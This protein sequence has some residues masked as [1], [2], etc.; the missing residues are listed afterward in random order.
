MG[1]FRYR[2]F[3]RLVETAGLFGFAVFWCL[4]A[5]RVARGT[6]SGNVWVVFPAVALGYLFADFIG[7]LVHFLADNFGDETL[8][9]FGPAFIRPFREHH[10]SPE[11]M[12]EHDY[13]E[14][15]GANALVA[16]FVLVP[17]ALFVDLLERNAGVAVGSFV[18]AWMLATL[19]T[20]SIHAWAHMEHPPVYARLMQRIGLA[21]SKAEHA[22]H[23]RPPHASHYCITTGWLNPVLERIAFFEH[24]RRVLRRNGSSVGTSDVAST[25]VESPES[26]ANELSSCRES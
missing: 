19:L 4:L 8:A 13:I 10:A 3:H 15:N 24:L 16:L 14:R 22:M 17:S 21:V 25:V 5:L 20:N 2:R 1:P 9:Y 26:G 7:G 18:C 11:K 6:C 23:H 12:C